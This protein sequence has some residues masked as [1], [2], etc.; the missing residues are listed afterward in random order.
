MIVTDCSNDVALYVA[1]NMRA[2]GRLLPVVHSPQSPGA[3]P[4]DQRHVQVRAATSGS[5]SS[6]VPE[7][8]GGLGQNGPVTAP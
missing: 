7:G 8:T 1:K 6:T 5:C 2:P 3:D 4:G